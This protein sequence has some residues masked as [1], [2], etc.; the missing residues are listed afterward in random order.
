LFDFNK[1]WLR[2]K[3]FYELNNLVRLLQKSPDVKIEMSAHTDNVGSVK[4]NIGLS[5]DRAMAVRQYLIAK[6]I[7]ADRI[8]SK[9][10]GKSKPIASNKTSAG[11]QLNRRVE[12]TVLKK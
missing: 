7:S 11:R 3:S 12:F 1:S 9:G 10:Y 2:T 6:G 5:N 4:Y 8:I